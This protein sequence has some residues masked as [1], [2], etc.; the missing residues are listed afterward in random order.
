MYSDYISLELGYT[1]IT[2]SYMQQGMPFFVP[3]YVI[4][5][6]FNEILC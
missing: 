5:W 4:L 6:Y 2:K 3:N 1:I